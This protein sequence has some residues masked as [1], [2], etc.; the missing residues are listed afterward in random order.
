MVL[1]KIHPPAKQDLTEP[2][3]ILK[4]KLP[5]EAADIMLFLAGSSV[6]AL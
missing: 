3:R 4:F 5:V 6:G 1:L 2:S